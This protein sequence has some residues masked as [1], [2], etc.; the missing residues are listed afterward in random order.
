VP[1]FFGFKSFN[2]DIIIV[3]AAFSRESCEERIHIAAGSRSYEAQANPT[4][5][6]KINLQDDKRG[7]IPYSPIPQS[8]NSCYSLLPSD[9][10]PPS[11]VI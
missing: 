9:L 2:V 5:E 11:S 3:G 7:W 8:R 6:Q 4:E 10:N 1:A